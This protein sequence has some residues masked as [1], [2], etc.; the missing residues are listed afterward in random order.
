[1]LSALRFFWREH[2]FL[3]LAFA[4]A[5][6]LTVFFTVRMVVFTLYW[7]DPAHR[8]QPIAG[9]MTPRYI[10]HSYD[11]PPELVRKVLNL[12][13]EPRKRRTLAEIARDSDLT[14]DEI[15]QRITQAAE[16]HHGSAE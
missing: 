6:A 1:M 7:A 2:R 16:A 11:L 10:V 8:N 4:M 12:E 15:A 13:E 3:F 14:L 5:L 9:W